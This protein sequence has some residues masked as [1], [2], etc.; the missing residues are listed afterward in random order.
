MPSE[1]GRMP[2]RN[3]EQNTDQDTRRIPNRPA[4]FTL[5]DSDRV[6]ANALLP[7]RPENSNHISTSSY[8]QG[9][10]IRSNYNLDGA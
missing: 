10:R 4:N 6:I 1:A 5:D 9:F 3:T 7:P 2:I 8:N